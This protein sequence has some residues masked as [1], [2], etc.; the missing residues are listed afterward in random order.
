[1]RYTSSHDDRSPP[2]TNVYIH[3]SPTSASSHLNTTTSSHL[4]STTSFTS[5][6]TSSYT[7][8]TSPPPT[9]PAS[10]TSSS[11]SSVFFGDFLGRSPRFRT[12]GSVSTASEH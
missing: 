5:S 10:S 2:A 8:Y 12:D 4:S 3:S 9:S 11:S 7:A 1:M 6:S